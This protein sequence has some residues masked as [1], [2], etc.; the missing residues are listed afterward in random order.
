MPVGAYE[1]MVALMDDEEARF[2]LAGVLRF[3][4][5]EIDKSHVGLLLPAACAALAGLDVFN[6]PGKTSIA[7]DPSEVGQLMGF[8]DLL[9]AVRDEPSV[10]AMVRRVA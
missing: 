3:G 2:K 10:Y 1:K 9:L 5:I 6:E 8:V 4:E 7:L